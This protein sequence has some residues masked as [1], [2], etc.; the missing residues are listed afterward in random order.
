MEQDP[1][2][3]SRCGDPL[4]IGA[5]CCGRC[6]TA[7]AGSRRV[8]GGAAAARFVDM[9]RL[10]PV[11]GELDDER[12]VR[13]SL[14]ILFRMAVGPSADFYAPRFLEYERTGRSFPSWNWASLWIPS[15]WAFYRKLWVP[16]FAYALWPLIAVA[17][18]GV[19]D[20]YLGDSGGVWL[21]CA[22]LVVWFVPG[23]VAALTA[24]SLV[25][26]NAREAVLKAE[27]ATPRP[28]DA[29][30]LLAARAPIAP[31]FAALLGGGAILLALTVAAPRLQTAYAAHVVRTQ[32]TLGLDAVKPFQRQVEE[33]WARSRSL[34][35]APDYEAVESQRGAE[36]LQAVSISPASGRLR[37]ALG[38]S[39]PEL[40]GSSIL[41]A[42]T[43]DG[44]Q[45]VHWI[46]IPIDIPAKYLP[47]QCRHR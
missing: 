29:A 33:W 31:G 41:L 39:I 16:G 43:M 3:C 19:I 44:R 36:F 24:N 40:A 30:A 13:P 11:P 38:P 1:L 20:P 12:V 26:R 28:E 27:V 15:A 46:C 45:H 17:A 4:N 32:V 8:A 42:P 47:L 21:A 7:V 2:S 5:G 22:W 35:T 25:Y 6:G 10:P 37:L 18:F 34:P 23:V 14:A 9:V